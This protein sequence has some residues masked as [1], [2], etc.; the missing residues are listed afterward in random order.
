MMSPAEAASLLKH[1]LKES[2]L[3]SRE[4]LTA[5]RTIQDDA[6]EA[7]AWVARKRSRGIAF[8]IRSLKSK[9]PSIKEW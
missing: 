7:A 4:L 6:I 1:C 8:D 9:P 3:G 2:K 5:I